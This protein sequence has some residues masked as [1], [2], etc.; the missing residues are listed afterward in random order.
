MVSIFHCY[1][2]LLLR[3]LDNDTEFWNKVKGSVLKEND[4][5]WKV[6]SDFTFN[7]LVYYV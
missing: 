2:F 4:Y 1:E 3:K 5:S 6:P 7:L